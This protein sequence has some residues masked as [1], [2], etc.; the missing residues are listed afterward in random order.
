MLGAPDDC[1]ASQGDSN[2]SD[3]ARCSEDAEGKKTTV[4]VAMH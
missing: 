4:H 1:S 3:D 2:L